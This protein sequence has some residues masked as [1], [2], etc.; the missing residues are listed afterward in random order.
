MAHDWYNLA[1]LTRI[2]GGKP[3][4]EALTNDLMFRFNSYRA[5]DA[6]KKATLGEAIKISILG[7]D[8]IDSAQLTEFTESYVKAG[9]KQDKF[10]Q[11]MIS[12]YKNA[13][14]SQANQ[15][16]EKL[17]LPYH[18]TLQEL[19]GGYRLSDLSD[20]ATGMSMQAPKQ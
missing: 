1:S 6:A 11:F 18:Q 9:G 7:G 3:L 5:A 4:D 10:A 12:Q 20:V 19:Q 13:T 14:V 8:N 15:L 17:S 16:R 2:A